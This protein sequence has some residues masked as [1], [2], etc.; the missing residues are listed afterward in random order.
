MAHHKMVH[1]PK[2]MIRK[3]KTRGPEPA[4][5]LKQARVQASE[6]NTN[7]AAVSRPISTTANHVNPIIVAM[8]IAMQPVVNI[9][10]ANGIHGELVG[11]AGVRFSADVSQR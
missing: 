2:P 1:W 4:T 9:R 6:P 11:A 10:I 5:K 7:M 8:E 3:L